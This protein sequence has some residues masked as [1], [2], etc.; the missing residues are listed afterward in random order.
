MIVVDETIV[1]TIITGAISLVGI[2]I[3]T[4]QSN[5]KIVNK[6]ETTQAVTDYKIE[7]LTHEVQRHST[8][9]EK[10]PVIEEQIKYINHR[11]DEHNERDD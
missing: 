3:S 6:I 4:S 2:L 11:L 10:I 1:T 7:G 5:R 9:V 8:L